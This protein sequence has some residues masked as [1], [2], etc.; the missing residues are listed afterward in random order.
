[1]LP[2]HAG[3]QAPRHR[4]PRRR[5]PRKLRPDG[6]GSGRGG[7]SAGR[8]WPAGA[9]DGVQRAVD[10]TKRGGNR[11]GVGPAGGEGQAGG[12]QLAGGE[13]EVVRAAEGGA[14][15]AGRELP[16]AAGAGAAAAQA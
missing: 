9:A 5:V 11:A 16:E 14:R 4:Q 10:P 6:E 3:P 13:G 7:R 12:G 1:M 8:V 15:E 2:E